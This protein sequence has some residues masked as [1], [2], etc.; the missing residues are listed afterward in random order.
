MTITEYFAQIRH[1]MQSLAEVQ[2]EQYVEQVL[3]ETRGNLRIRVRFADNALLEVSEA[4]A[5]TEGR[6]I[7]WL[8]YRYH[9]QTGEG[10]ILFRYDNAPHHHGL[11]TFPHH[12]HT[13]EGVTE[14]DRCSLHEVIEEI[15]HHE[16]S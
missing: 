13:A 9:F 10:V 15:K 14:S 12:K 11:S 4:V 1:L 16:G 3:T 8:S 2:F 5:I 7:E 6:T